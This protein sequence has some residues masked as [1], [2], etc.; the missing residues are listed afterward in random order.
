MNPGI[1]PP[2]YPPVTF[3]ASPMMQVQPEKPQKGII[4]TIFSIFSG[5]FGGGITPGTGND[6]P[7]ANNEPVGDLPP[8]MKPVTQV[9]THAPQGQ[10]PHDITVTSPKAG[11]EILVTEPIKIAWTMPNNPSGTVSL[12]LVRHDG[13]QFTGLG[14]TTVPNTGQYT[15]YQQDNAHD[16]GLPGNVDCFG[17]LSLATMGITDMIQYANAWNLPPTMDCTIDAS[18]DPIDPYPAFHGSSGMFTLKNPYAFFE[19]DVDGDS[20]GYANVQTGFDETSPWHHTIYRMVIK[21]DLT[22]LYENQKVK[23]A[24]LTLLLD[25]TNVGTADGTIHFDNSRS[26]IASVWI[27]SGNYP[28]EKPAAQTPIKFNYPAPATGGS[29]G[30]VSFDS[31]SRLVTIDMTEGL[32]YWLSDNS[33]E[34]DSVVL[35]GS[36][37]SEGNIHVYQHSRYTVVSFTVER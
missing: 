24:T 22:G 10:M 14:H 37:E 6:Q 29:T 20:V 31:A 7:G 23:K 32:N 19:T 35:V 17:G 15:W 28:G 12:K 5:F 18:T 30:H 9:T 8:G 2:A 26:S 16:C 11:E 25:Y 36:D 4:E 1:T 13:S 34:A 33:A 3:E 27:L 21:P